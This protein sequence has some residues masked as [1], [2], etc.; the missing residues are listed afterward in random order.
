MIPIS[1]KEIF[2]PHGRKNLS[3]TMV[4]PLS[5][6][7][8]IA[9]RARGDTGGNSS[10]P[11]TTPPHLLLPCLAT[12]QA[13]TENH[14][15]ARAVAAGPSP[16]SMEA[17]EVRAHDQYQDDRGHNGGRLELARLIEVWPQQ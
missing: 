14:T 1:T 5:E 8:C 12:A 9:P 3:E 11:A 10:S 17:S 16:L 15:A 2:K 6:G 13:C 4:E 7:P